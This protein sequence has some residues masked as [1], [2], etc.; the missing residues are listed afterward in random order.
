MKETMPIGFKW[1]WCSDCHMP[2]IRCP[3]CGNNCC[4]ALYGVTVDGSVCD[5]CPSAYIYQD[6]HF[7]LNEWPWYYN[8]FMR[9]DR[10][11]MYGRR[12][13]NTIFRCLR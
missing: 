5:V 10:W 6:K 3:K 8:W 2:F 11:H 7:D 4:N 12:V 9:F 1:E 13:Y